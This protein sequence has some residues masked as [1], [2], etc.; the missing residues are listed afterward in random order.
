M[1][2]YFLLTAAGTFTARRSHLWQVVY[3]KKGIEGGYEAIR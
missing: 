1:W 3:S 2:R